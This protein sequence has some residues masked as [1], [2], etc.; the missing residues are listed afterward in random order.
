[1]DNL[2]I[3][4]PAGFYLWMV[5]LKHEAIEHRRDLVLID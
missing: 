3:I 4:I 2:V 1:M 5:S